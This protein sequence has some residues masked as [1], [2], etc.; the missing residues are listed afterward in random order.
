MY[1]LRTPRFLRS[2]AS[3]FIRFAYLF[4]ASCNGASIYVQTNCKRFAAECAALIPR[5][6]VLL[7]DDLVH[8]DIVAAYNLTGLLLTSLGLRVASPL[9]GKCHSSNAVAL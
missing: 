7:R 5:Y 2:Y 6:K 4:G 8:Q 1:T 9:A 3:H